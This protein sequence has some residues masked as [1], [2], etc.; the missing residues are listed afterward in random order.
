MTTINKISPTRIEIVESNEVR[1]EYEK[2][3]LEAA[4]IAKTEEIS[5]INSLLK[6]FEN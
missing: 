6:Y 1:K 5:Y 3:T 4:K 2:A